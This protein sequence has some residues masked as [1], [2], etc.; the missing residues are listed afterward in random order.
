MINVAVQE[1]E[2]VIALIMLREGRRET[3]VTDGGGKAPGL[4]GRG[5]SLGFLVNVLGSCWDQLEKWTKEGR[6]TGSRV[7][8][9]G[10]S[11]TSVRSW[12][13]VCRTDVL[14]SVLRWPSGVFLM[15]P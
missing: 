15:S 2:E 8:P 1:T 5:K 14:P 10:L 11:G 9:P 7:E 4:V 12:S 6:G 13:S 3:R